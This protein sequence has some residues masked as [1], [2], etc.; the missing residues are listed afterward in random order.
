LQ[1][2]G[3]QAAHAEAKHLERTARLERIRELAEKEGDAKTLERVN[4][5][6][7]KEQQRYETKTSRI[8]A[9]RDRAAQFER[10]RRDGN[11]PGRPGRAETAAESE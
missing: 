8:D 3:E 5:L 1:A 11:S 7:K 2:L 9:R 4:A 10:R 6:M